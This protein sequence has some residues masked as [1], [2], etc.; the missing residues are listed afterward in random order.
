VGAYIQG[1]I[2]AQELPADFGLLHGTTYDLQ[3]VQRA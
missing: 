2:V 1:P 3:V